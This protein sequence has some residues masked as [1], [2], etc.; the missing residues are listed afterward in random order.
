MKTCSMPGRAESSAVRLAQ[1]SMTVR[2]RAVPSPA[3]EPVCSEEKT[4]TSQRPNPGPD[5]A[6]LTVSAES[7]A[8][9]A[10]VS[11]TA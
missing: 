4:T 7:A 2:A 1:A 6:E 8:A 10:K 9:S 11:S 3:K 5:N